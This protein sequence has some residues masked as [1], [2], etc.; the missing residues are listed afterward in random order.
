[1]EIDNLTLGEE[2]EGGS[3]KKSKLGGNH[4]QIRLFYLEGKL[5]R[6]NN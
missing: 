3:S 5:L 2:F 4:K 6:I 1:V